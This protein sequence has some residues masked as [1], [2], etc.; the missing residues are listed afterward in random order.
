METKNKPH[1][2]KKQTTSNPVKPVPLETVQ[3][4]YALSFFSKPK[5]FKH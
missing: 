4:Y 1:D 5:S 2:D 3:A